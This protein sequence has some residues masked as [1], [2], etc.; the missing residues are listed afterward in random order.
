MRIKSVLV[1]VLLVLVLSVSAVA[2]AESTFPTF[3]KDNAMAAFI[4]TRAV[5][6]EKGA[7]AEWRKMEG[8]AIDAVNKRFYVAVTAVQKGMSDDK[9]DIHLKDNP[10]G[11]VF[12][13]TYDDSYNVSALTPV[14]IGGPYDKSNADYSCNPDA[15]SNPDNLFVDPK[16][17]LWIGEDTDYHKNQFL[18]MWDGKALKRFAAMPRGA[19]TTGLRIEKTGTLFSNVQHPD[20]DN[21]YPFNRG[22]IGT[23]TGFKAGDDFTSLPIPKGD[24][25]KRL[26]V[27]AG[28]YQILGRM[29]EAI[30]GSSEVFGAIVQADG[31][32]QV[33]CNNP[34]GNMYL[35]TASDGSEGYLYTNCEYT[36]GG[37]SRLY[38]KQNTDGTWKVIEGDLVGFHNVGGTW[39]NCNA[40]VTPWNTA[41]T[42]EEYAPD[43][44]DEWDGGWV[45]VAQ[46]MTDYL[47]KK[48]NPY[49]VGYIV[50][51]RPGGGEDGGVGTNV[52]KHYAMGRFSHEMALVMPDSKTVYFGDDGTD[53]VLYKFIADKAED[54]SA[55]SLYAAKITQSGD[56]LN[57]SWVLLGKGNDVDIAKEVDALAAT[58]K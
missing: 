41:L 8:V 25:T 50:E 6:I 40:S 47:G 36:P 29:G 13:G 27:A 9:G 48:A 11:A 51:M 38:I 58:L 4:N 26:T 30:P 45:P 34:D 39:N 15:I 20:A 12:M 37:V 33:I 3:P 5:A 56:T 23:V 24:D 57:L 16:G 10:C 31:K 7:T 43:V 22:V 49:Q 1:S 17:N 19:E 52:V 32:T 28:K 54:L 46:A 21:L 53:R 14:V 55:G 44:A 2:R 35:P 42:A 18:W